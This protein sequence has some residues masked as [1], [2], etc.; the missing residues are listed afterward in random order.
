MM[1]KTV[2]ICDTEPVVI[3]GIRAVLSSSPDL[4]FA[5]AEGTVSSG[6]ELVSRLNPAVVLIDKAFG[7]HAVV[8]WV[9]RMAASGRTAAV[10]WGAPIHGAEAL[11]LMQAGARGVI[12]K[13]AA[14]QSLMECLRA[15]AAGRTW[16]EPS[17]LH[18]PEAAV[19]RNRSQLT[20][21]EQQ[22]LELVERGLK[23]R[24]IAQQLGICP[25]TVKIHLRHIFEKTGIHGRYGLALNGLKE[26]GLLSL[27][28]N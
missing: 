15:V 23:N 19:R 8:D 14:V 18:D 28:T 21:R 5:G 16:M 9:S 13:T 4:R 25:G 22:V 10:V 12:R 17:M 27:Q 26:K 2:A 7:M 20:S 11:R 6:E 3:D 24:D 1:G